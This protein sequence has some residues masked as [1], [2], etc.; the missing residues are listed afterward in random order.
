MGILGNLLGRKSGEIDKFKEAVRLL[1]E[2]HEPYIIL[3]KSKGTDNM[4][5]AARGNVADMTSLY[6]GGVSEMNLI[7][8]VYFALVMYATMQSI[9]APPRGKEN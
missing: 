7:Q 8:E 1:H 4:N 6:L 9:G 2:L 5:L 3:A